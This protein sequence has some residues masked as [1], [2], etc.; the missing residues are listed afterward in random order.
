MTWVVRAG[1]HS[2]LVDQF[3]DEG[4]VGISAGGA[5]DET[6]LGKDRE[7]ISAQLQQLRPDWSVAKVANQAGQLYRFLEEISPG[8][9]VLTYDSDNRK[10]FV[11]KVASGPR[12]DADGEELPFVRSVKWTHRI[13]RDW[14]SVPTR[15][16]LGAIQT[17]FR[18]NPEASKE[19]DALKVE[20]DAPVT[21]TPKPS[22][23]PVPDETEHDV[24]GQTLE[25][26]HEFIEDL[27]QKLDPYE[28][29][30]LIAG[31]LRAMGYKTRV[32]PRGPDRGLDIFASP[33]GLGLEEPRI[34]VEVKHRSSSMGAPDIRSFLGGRQPGDRCL[35]IST[36]G[37]SR[38]ARYEAERSNTPLT[39]VTL[40]QVRELLLEHYEELD[41]E[42]RRLVPLRRIYWPVTAE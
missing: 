23:S 10:Y 37:F 3:I 30:D 14:V 27:I 16:S 29:Q 22:V 1:R 24:Y 31:I 11:G 4:V 35:F 33:D 9:D 18:L 17:L 42:A 8:D 2:A 38:E 32:A 15:N 13:A 6:A 7:A 12:Y 28:F 34:F 5:F 40:P 25:K 20:I 26:S 39:L 19:L 21:V 36:G 41:A